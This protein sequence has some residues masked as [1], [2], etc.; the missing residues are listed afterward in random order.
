MRAGSPDLGS[1]TVGKETFR[2]LLK[3]LKDPSIHVSEQTLNDVCVQKSF[4]VLR[5]APVPSPSLQIP[6][7]KIMQSTFSV[8][9]LVHVS[10][11]HLCVLNRRPGLASQ[12][13]VMSQM[14]LLST[15]QLY[16]LLIHHSAP[17]TMHG[18]DMMVVQL[19]LNF[20][21]SNM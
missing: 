6:A 17:L 16:T 21:I 12:L 20:G 2:L 4:K 14:S 5:L 10:T 1:G 7:S 8:Y 9:A 19:E 18:C 11:S 15:E 13:F 3:E